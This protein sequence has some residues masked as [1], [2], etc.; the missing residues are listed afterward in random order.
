MD[1]HI[2]VDP[3]GVIG[4]PFMLKCRKKVNFQQI[5]LIFGKNM[6]K[7]PEGKFS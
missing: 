1:Y 4:D 7:P 2:I 6:V 3:V 5:G